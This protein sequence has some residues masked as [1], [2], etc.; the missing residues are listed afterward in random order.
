[1]TRANAIYNDSDTTLSPNQTV[2]KATLTVTA[3]DKSR[4]Y[5]DANPAFTA[6][7]GGFKNGET[8]ATSG[9]TGS[10]SLSTT[11]SAA[12]PV[13]SYTITAA[14]GTL[15]AGN[16]SFSFAHGQLTVTPASLTVTADDKSRE[17]GDPNPVFTASYGGFKNGET[18]ATSGVTGSPSLATTATAT[19]SVAGGPYTITAAV[20]TLAAGNYT[21]SFASG[22]LTVT[23]ASLTVTADDKS[24][25]YGDAN[26]AFTASYGG[27]KNG[28]TLATSGVTG[29]PSLATT[30][31][32]TSSV[33][34]SP[35]TITA[36][37]GTLAAGNYSFSFAHGQLTV[38]PASLTVTA[39]D[40][41]REYGD[42]NPV[43]TASYGGFKNSETFATSGVTG[44]PSLATTATA[45]SSVAGGPYTI[46]AAVG[47]LAA[48]NYTFSFAS[49][50]LT[51]TKASLTV[52]ADD[53]SRQYGDANPA[54]TASYGG[55]K[56]GET[57]AT[58]GVTGSPSLATT[59]TATSS[60]AGSPYTITAAA[61]TLAAGNYSF[62]FAHGQL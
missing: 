61:G 35:Y 38:T 11:A 56:N 20:G 60:V 8:L 55:F 18:F 51:V 45:T 43:F 36:A 21:F 57:F 58:S 48:G 15:A 37:A 31:T 30:A 28:E 16:Y 22:E 25:Q 5:G 4:Q 27:F 50:E 62:S 40:K 23:K 41:S 14:A 6:S 10:P 52:T 17:Y 44:S 39:D 3:D 47:T 32:A 26:P 46:T 9:V 34:G 42:P 29:S 24:R 19:S 1:M 54:F 13:A 7:Y 53:K 59:A 12:S 33:A 49:G 2:N